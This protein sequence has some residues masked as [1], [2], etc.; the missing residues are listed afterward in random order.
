ME[1]RF[2]LAVCR[3]TGSKTQEILTS[4]CS[5]VKASSRCFSLMSLL[6]ISA[7]R[8]RSKPGGVRKSS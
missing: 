6:P 2:L 3:S 7:L 4:Q 5:E 1:P 8:V